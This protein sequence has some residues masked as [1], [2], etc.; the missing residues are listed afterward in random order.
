MFRPFAKAIIRLN[1]FKIYKN[2][3]N[4]ISH[5]SSM[6]QRSIEHVSPYLKCQHICRAAVQVNVTL[7]Q[8]TKAQN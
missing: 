1:H 3:G 5:I 4:I 6:W 7:K 8:A 2:K